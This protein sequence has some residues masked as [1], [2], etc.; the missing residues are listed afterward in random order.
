MGINVLGARAIIECVRV[1]GNPHAEREVESALRWHGLL[2]DDERLLAYAEER[3]FVRAGGESYG[4]VFR[5]ESEDRSGRTSRR[6]VY[7]KA[8]VTGCGQAATETAVREQVGRLKRLSGWGIRTPRVYGSGRGTIYLEHVE[9]NPPDPAR[10]LEE[11]A[12]T[13][14]ILDFRGAHPID[15]VSDLVER[16]G[17]L[18]YVDA[19]SDLGHLAEGLPPNADRPARRTLLWAVAGKER[20]QAESAYARAYGQLARGAMR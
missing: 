19:G 9:G 3:D 7:A 6:T 20:P 5:V 17:E 2:A 14:A 11:L 10:H 16:G 1:A 13:A 8:V 12:R 18:F 4:A 15:F